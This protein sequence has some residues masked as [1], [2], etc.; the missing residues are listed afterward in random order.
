MSRRAFCQWIATWGFISKKTAMHSGIAASIAPRPQAGARSPGTAT[1]RNMNASAGMASAVAAVILNETA[2]AAKSS[3]ATAHPNPP[4]L[5]NSAHAPSDH[6]TQATR[7][8]SVT[9]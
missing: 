8:A 2:M 7:S 3:V 6:A 1:A 9:A 4:V 5:R